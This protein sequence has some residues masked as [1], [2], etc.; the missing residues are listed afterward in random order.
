MDK[1]PLWAIIPAKG[2][3]RRY[4]GKNAKLAPYVIRAAIEAN[5]F[6]NVIVS[7]DDGEILFQA[8]SLGADIYNRKP[9]LCDDG[10]TAAMVVMDVMCN[11]DFPCNSFAVLWPTNPL[12]TPKTLNLIT[13]T[14]LDA[15]VE[16]AYA[17]RTAIFMTTRR[18]LRILKFDGDGMS[19]LVPRVEKIDVNEPQDLAEAEAILASRNR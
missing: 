1:R 10:V 7:S 19:L 3:S 6:D 14:F 11:L 4:P 17:D 2:N 16:H 5:C 12:I 18:F 15:D 8:L 13:H 9:L